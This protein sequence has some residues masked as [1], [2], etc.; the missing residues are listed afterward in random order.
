MKILEDKNVQHTIIEYLKNPIKN[1]ELTNII[2]ILNIHPIDL[3][4]KNEQDF[5]DLNLDSSQLKND[6]L[7]IECIINHPK[8]MQR[9]III[10]GDKGVIGRPPEKIFDIL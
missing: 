9:P 3:I 10:N 1:P 6:R 7:L 5:K 2:K 4:R 8:I